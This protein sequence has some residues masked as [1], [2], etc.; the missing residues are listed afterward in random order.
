MSVRLKYRGRELTDR[1]ITFIRGL[2]AEHPEASRRALS[3][4]LCEAWDWR[5]P[6][7]Q[8]CDMVC[9]G[10][11]LALHRADWIELPP[12]RQVSRNNV[13]ARRRPAPIHVDQTPVRAKLSEIRPLQIRQVRRSEDEALFD[14]LIEEHHY[15]AYTRPVGEHLK[16]LVEAHG[17]PIACL[18]WSSA[19]RHLGPRDRFIGWSG[20]ARRCNIRYLA[21]NSRFL[22]LPW[23]EVRYLA[24]HLLSRV[25]HV[26]PADWEKLYAHP[27]Y[28]LETFVDPARFAGTC[29]RA[30]NWK[31][32]GLT[33]GRGKDAPTRKPTRSKKRVLG[34]PLR[35]DFRQR[36]AQV[37]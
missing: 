2:I 23:V 7:G 30:A 26:L 10:L 32:L 31:V 33:T 21:Y 28:Y 11:M 25:A 24:S 15:L 4:I 9:R 8:L 27:I 3:A 5:Q 12:V 13:I 36:L 1:D 17:R 16:Y 14:S 29:Y 22:I 19:P 18:A 6:N 20:E 35:A 37:S 34:Y